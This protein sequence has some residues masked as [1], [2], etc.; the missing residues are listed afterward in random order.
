MNCNQKFYRC[1]RCGKM[2]GLILDGAGVLSCCGAPMEL[3]VANSVDA[4]GEKHVPVLERDGEE[5]IVK[6]GS[7]EHP[8]VEEHYIEWV[9]ICTGAGGQRHILAPGNAPEVRFNVKQGEPVAVYAYCNVHGLW[10]ADMSKYDFKSA[11]KL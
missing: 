9:Y 10:Q 6:I 8:M 2:V 1:N 5:L 7:V 3:L 11:C 4:S